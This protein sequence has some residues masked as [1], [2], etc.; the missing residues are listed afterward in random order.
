MWCRLDGNARCTTLAGLIFASLL[1]EKSGSGDG[2]RVWC[3]L[4][5]CSPWGGHG[6]VGGVAGASLGFG[7]VLAMLARVG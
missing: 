7:G 2:V 3:L 1:F 4:S 6:T 5:L